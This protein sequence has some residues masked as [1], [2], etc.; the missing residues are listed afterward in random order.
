MPDYLRLIA[1]FGIAVVNVQFMAFSAGA[2]FAYPPVNST[3][4]AIT[5]WLVNGL[6]LLKTYGLFSFMFGVSLGFMERSADRRGLPFSRIYRNRM[7]GLLVLG[8]AHGCLFFPGDILTIYGVAGTMLYRFRNWPARRLTQ[9]G[10]ILLFVQTIIAPALILATPETPADVIALEQEVMTRGNF[11]DAALFRCMS[12]AYMMPSLLLL[13]GLAALGWFCLGLAAVKSG[14]IEHTG[15]PLWR[16]ARRSCLAPGVV[17]SLIGAAIWQ[18]GAL[19]AGVIIT[20]FVAPLATLGYLGLIATLAARPEPIITRMQAAGGSSLSIYLGQ[21]IV[22]STLFANYGLGLWG[23]VDRLTAVVIALTTTTA[24]LMAL[25]IW[26]KHIALGP[27]EWLLRKITYAKLSTEGR[28][29]GDPMG[30]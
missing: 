27:F 14:M 6:T 9:V 17:L 8:I 7:I 24:L 28:T 15:H 2:N 19:E 29:S 25:S 12:F 13:Q 21:S 30:T 20:L 22:L 11:L 10:A 4:D 23:K 1:L 16:R 26:R 18:W 3:A 5:L